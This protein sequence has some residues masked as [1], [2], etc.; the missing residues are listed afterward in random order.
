MTGAQLKTVYLPRGEAA[1]EPGDGVVEAAVPAHDD[2]GLFTRA[3]AAP[4][5]GLGEA[6]PAVVVFADPLCPFSRSAVAQLAAQ[7][8]AGRLRLRVA[9]VGLLGAASAERA[10]VIASSES[11]ALAWFEAGEPGRASAE[12]AARIEANNA[13]FAA[14]GESS[15]PLMVWRARDGRVRRHRGDI[16]PG[17]LEAWVA[18]LER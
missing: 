12:G 16:E 2:E 10:I 17:A 14:W 15:V 1:A 9:P 6:G 13:L 5:F 4:G 7:A 11:G 3:A 18:G 8:L